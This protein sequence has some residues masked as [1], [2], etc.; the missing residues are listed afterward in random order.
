MTSRAAPRR[1]SAARYRGVVNIAIT[2]ERERLAA[3]R[4]RRRVAQPDLPRR[5]EHAVIELVRR[6]S[7]PRRGDHPLAVL[8]ERGRPEP[9]EPGLVGYTEQ[10]LRR[11]LRGEWKVRARSPRR[12]RRCSPPEIRNAAGRRRGRADCR[13]LI[14][15]PL[16][17]VRTHEAR[18]G[19][20]DS[21]RITRGRGSNWQ[22]SAHRAH[23]V[24]ARVVGG[25]EGR[26]PLTLRL[27]RG[28]PP[29]GMAE[30]VDGRR[31]HSP[32]GARRQQRIAT[33]TASAG[34]SRVWLPCRDAAATTRT[35][36]RD[37]A[38]AAAARCSRRPSSSSGPSC[39]TRGSR[40]TCEDPR[41]ERVPCDERAWPSRENDARRERAHGGGQA[42]RE[43]G[44]QP[45]AVGRARG[46]PGLQRADSRA[47]GLL[48]SRTR[49]PADLGDD[50]PR[51]SDSGV[52]APPR[53]G[54]D[55]ET[56]GGPKGSRRRRR[57]TGEP[58]RTAPRQ[59][60]P[61]SSSSVALPRATGAPPASDL[62]AFQEIAGGRT[63][64]PC[65]H[66]TGERR[67]AAT[68]APR[69]SAR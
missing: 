34:V 63:G 26:S 7:V 65:S 16:S 45:A 22:S 20:C 59:T 30:V 54:R 13:V 49:P 5:R 67:C 36:Q 29:R 18:Y 27:P 38:R 14:N 42:G 23:H 41:A 15:P 10:A 25:A 39:A 61:L 28:P 64:D 48:G 6:S 37:A 50:R 1:R 31:R 19:I 56:G 51:S 4:P 11:R 46:P 66:A 44:D 68:S 35:V 53:G 47:V 21:R 3:R 24:G 32:G 43:G 69:R 52:V 9:D 2:R 8:V 40:S 17:G 57:P 33:V 60:Q 58:A 12:C 62:D 55:E